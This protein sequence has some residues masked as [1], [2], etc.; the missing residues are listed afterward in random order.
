[1]ALENTAVKSF[2]V[3]YQGSSSRG[4]TVFTDSKYEV[5][6]SGA[7]FIYE[8]GDEPKTTI[9]GPGVWLRVEDPAPAEKSPAAPRR[10]R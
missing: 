7:L 1:M 3:T 4:T 6:A 10:L 2:K 8:G 5:H 9:F